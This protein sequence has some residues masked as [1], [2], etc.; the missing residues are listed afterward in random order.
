MAQTEPLR[1][2][3]GMHQPKRHGKILFFRQVEKRTENIDNSID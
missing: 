3:M 2:P 1:E